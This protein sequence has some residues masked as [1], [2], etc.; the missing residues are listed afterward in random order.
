M[1]GRDVRSLCK[2]IRIIVYSTV[3]VPHDTRPWNWMENDC[4]VAVLSYKT[5]RPEINAQ[6]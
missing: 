1:R 3:Y 6:Y 4:V 5:D 2:F